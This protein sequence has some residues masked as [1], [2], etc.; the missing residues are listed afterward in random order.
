MSEG[1]TA[2]KGK[3]NDL[4]KTGDDQ[5]CQDIIDD[6]KGKIDALAWDDTKSVKENLT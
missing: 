1:K 5:A 4:L 6:A 2:L 3:L